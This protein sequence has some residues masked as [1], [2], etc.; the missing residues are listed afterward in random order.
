MDTRKF[1]RLMEEHEEA[2]VSE[3]DR[4]WQEAFDALYVDEGS[5]E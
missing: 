2:P 3:Q 1:D 4:L 5:G